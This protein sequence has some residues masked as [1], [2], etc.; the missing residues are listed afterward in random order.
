VRALLESELARASGGSYT[1]DGV[2]LSFNDVPHGLFATRDALGAN[3][4]F[5]NGA[6]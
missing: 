3:I 5:G 2:T 1:D 4:V 6:Q